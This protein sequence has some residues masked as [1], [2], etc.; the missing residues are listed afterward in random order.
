MASEGY[1]IYCDE[2]CHLEHDQQRSMVLGAVWCPEAKTAEIAARLREIKARHGLAPWFEAKWGKVSQGQLSYYM[3]VIDYFFDDDDLYFR[4]LIVPDKALL[5]H[6][7]FDQDHDEFYFKMYFDMLKLLLSNESWYYIY[8]DIKDSR[9]A[10]KVAKLHEVLSNS[11]YDFRRQ[12]VRRIQ[13]VRSNEVEQVQLADM[14]VGA[15]SYANRELTGSSAKAALI[16]RIRERSGYG[17]TRSTL[18]REQKMNLFRW[19]PR[20]SVS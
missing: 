18:L 3:D 6:N 7:E 8:L 5:R 12:I 13:T 10:A 4:A 9:S 14:L 16:A 1:A 2:S 15:I 19:E 20:V 17:L 11:R